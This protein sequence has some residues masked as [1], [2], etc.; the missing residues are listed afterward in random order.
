MIPMPR[1][2]SQMSWKTTEAPILRP[3]SMP[4]AKPVI[5]PSGEQTS[6]VSFASRPK[7]PASAMLQ[8][9]SVLRQCM[10]P[11]G[12]PV[13][14]LATNSDDV[15]KF[16]QPGPQRLRHRLVI[17]AAEQLG[18]DQQFRFGEIEHV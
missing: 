18:H 6:I 1:F 4:A 7:R 2:G 14:P 15:L 8:A 10:T 5:W 17:E 16:R 13:R 3:S 12:E 11:L 9:N